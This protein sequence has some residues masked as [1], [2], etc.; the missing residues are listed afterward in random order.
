MA[1][2]RRKQ[3]AWRETLRHTPG[4]RLTKQRCEVYRVLLETRDHPTAALVYERVRKRMPCVSP[5][6]VYNCLDAL[7]EKK[8]VNQVTF[9][10]GPSRYCPN[11]VDH[12]HLMD[13]ETGAVTDAPFQEGVCLESLLKL[14]ED[15]E[16]SN[17][18][19]Y[20]RVRKKM[21]EDQDV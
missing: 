17:V 21:K 4:L 6:T 7:T 13:E 5:A 3:P 10:R 18:E 1:T 2:S 8:L 20:V 15:V 12:V 14:P 19:I 16:I 9:D 11:L